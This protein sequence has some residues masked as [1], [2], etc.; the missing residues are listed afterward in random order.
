MMETRVV[1]FLLLTA[2]TKVRLK[3]RY[4]LLNLFI[5]VGLEVDGCK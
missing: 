1:V 3:M 5:L 4:V 2:K